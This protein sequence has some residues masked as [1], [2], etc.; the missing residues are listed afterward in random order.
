[1]LITSPHPGRH[2]HAQILLRDGT[3]DGNAV[4]EVI[5]RN[6][7]KLPSRMSRTDVIVDVGAHIGCFSI[8]CLGRG[9]GKAWCYEP[10]KDNATFLRKNVCQFM[11]AHVVEKAVWRSDKSE[12][13]IF[14]GY[15]EGQSTCGSCIPGCTVNGVNKMIP[16]ATIA[17]DEILEKLG[18]VRLL[19]IDAE[20][21]EYPILGTATKLDLV[22]EICGEL[23]HVAGLEHAWNIPAFKT[24]STEEMQNYLCDQGF[25]YVDVEPMSGRRTSLFWAR[26]GS[27]H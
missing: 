18:K 17:L 12:Q 13:V 5:R 24:Y 25:D 8:A 6:C 2:A 15:P 4:N 10:D 23:H 9:A 19:K 14:S 7:Y 16:V 27:P 22:E 1:M 3:Q 11:G 20:G 21:A 26:R